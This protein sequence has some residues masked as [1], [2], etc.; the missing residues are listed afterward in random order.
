L[1]ERAAGSSRDR[2]LV[3]SSGRIYFVRTAVDWSE[4]AGSYVRLHVGAQE[5]LV[6]DTMSRFEGDLDPHQ[7]VRIHRSPI[8]NID[9]IRDCGRRSTA[10]T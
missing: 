4:A 3:K 1:P 6:R 9:R 5:H 10:N 2:M 7:F 8:V